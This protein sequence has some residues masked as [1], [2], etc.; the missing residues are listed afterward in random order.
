VLLL[1]RHGESEANAAGLLLGRLESPLT[2]RGRDQASLL[3]SG[4]GQAVDRV[5]CSP[6]G[7]ARHTA[8]I[9]AE[10]CSVASVDVDERWIEVDYG[11]LDGTPLAAVPGD[12]WRRWQRDPAF[13]PPRG[14]A[15]AD[16]GRRVRTACR[17]LVGDDGGMARAERHVVVV[18]HVSPIKAAVAWALGVGDEV[19]WRM[20]LATGSITVVGWGA[21]GPSLHGFNLPS[22]WSPPGGQTSA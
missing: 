19:A 21:T 16:V 18:S 6:L 12:L 1:A 17:D 11:D 15:L 3:G 13:A 20:F 14:E 10:A 2:A 9:V 5:V 22:G 8:E 7:R 4:L